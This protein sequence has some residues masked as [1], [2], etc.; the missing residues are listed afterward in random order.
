VSSCKSFVFLQTERRYLE[1]PFSRA[2]PLILFRTNLTDHREFTRYTNCTAMRVI[3]SRYRFGSD[4]AKA[5]IRTLLK[6]R[7]LPLLQA[8]AT[9]PPKSDWREI[10]LRHC[11]REQN[12]LFRRGRRRIGHFKEATNDTQTP[13]VETYAMGD[14]APLADE[15]PL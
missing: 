10:R 5:K 4:A 6:A 3:A 9:K 8:S 12:K 14:R 13:Q 11:V 2:I 7:R 15:S 1:W